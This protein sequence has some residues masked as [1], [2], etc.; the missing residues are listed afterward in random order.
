MSILSY[1]WAIVTLILNVVYMGITF[2][3]FKRNISRN[4]SKFFEALGIFIIGPLI[5]NWLFSY[6]EFALNLFLPIY[7][8]LFVDVLGSTHMIMGKTIRNFVFFVLICSF[9]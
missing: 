6:K 9:L 5:F 2:N 7:L 8:A 4:T 3:V 1:I